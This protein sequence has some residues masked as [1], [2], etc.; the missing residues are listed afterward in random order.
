MEITDEQALK[1]REHEARMIPGVDGK[2]IFGFPNTIITKLRYCMYG[3]ITAA[4]G[5]RSLNVFAANGIFDPDITGI[6]HQPLYRDQYAAIYDQYVVIGSKIT[7]HFISNVSYNVIVGINGNDDSIFPT[8]VETLMEGNN[9]TWAVMAQGTGGNNVKTLTM[10]FEPNEAFGVD[11]KSDGY[12]ATAQGANPTELWCYG[13]WCAASD[14][15]STSTCQIA[16]EIDYT[17][18]F[19]ELADPTQS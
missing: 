12:S 17:V 14:G 7:V 10:T 6:G 8:T 1:R 19:T 13:V 5:A 9:N 16:V 15:S 4:S 3:S 2:R 11:T 18:K